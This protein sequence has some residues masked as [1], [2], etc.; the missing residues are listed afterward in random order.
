MIFENSVPIINSSPLNYANT[1][2]FE[3]LA[4]KK[5]F[6]K[7]KDECYNPMI[8]MLERFGIE[9]M[10]HLFYNCNLKDLRMHG[11][12]KI[13]ERLLKAVDHFKTFEM[14]TNEKGELVLSDKFIEG[15]KPNANFEP[16]T[17]QEL[18]ALLFERT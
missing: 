17:R 11:G 10:T 1:G 12:T 14:I 9:F 8:Q 18:R 7:V 5:A 15:L 3:D 16:M 2:M 13:P 4:T 6:Q